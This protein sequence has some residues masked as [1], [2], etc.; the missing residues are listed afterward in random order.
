MKLRK[1][2]F[3]KKWR[4][5]Y[6]IVYRTV[7]GTTQFLP[8]DWEQKI[9]EFYGKLLS[10]KIQDC[11][12]T[13]HMDETF[14]PYEAIG[15][16]TLEKAGAHNVKVKTGGQEKD[17]CTVLLGGMYKKSTGLTYQ[18]PPF[19]IFKLKSSGE[20]VGPR[21]MEKAKALGVYATTTETGWMDEKTTYPCPV[22]FFSRAQKF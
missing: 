8:A 20:V 11:D 19:F 15:K 12:F 22:I 14:V 16:K 9:D 18:L 21:F 1:M 6:N 3:F 4:R 13:F 2:R 10:S 5:Y 17:G 7:S